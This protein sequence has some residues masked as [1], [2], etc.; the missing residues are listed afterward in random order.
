MGR[1]SY[2]DRYMVEDCYSIGIPW[3][4]RHDFFCGFK[5]RVI[6]WKNALGEITSNI[7]IQVS[8]DEQIYGEKYIR[9]FYTHTSRSTEEK[10][11]L[12]YKVELVTTPCNLGGVRYWF[13]CPLVI[14]GEHSARRVGKLYLPPITKYF[15]CRH[16]YDLT[17]MSCRESHKFDRLFADIA[18][19]I[20]GATPNMVKQVL[21]KKGY[22]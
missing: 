20:P 14:N 18:I 2:S 8:T 19:N 3:L 12:D 11:E 13:I 16:C 10:T 15:G 9:L 7:G 17:Y 21:T 4:S 6:E 22:K 5:T 1:L